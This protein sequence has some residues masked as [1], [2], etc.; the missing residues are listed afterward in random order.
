MADV[1]D[2][3]DAYYARAPLAAAARRL[4]HRRHR[5]PRARRARCRSCSTGSAP[6]WPSCAAASTGCGPTSRS[7]PATTGS[8]RTSAT[9]SAPT[10]STLDAARAAARRGQD[11]P[12]P[13]P[14]GHA[15]GPGGAGARRHRLERR[16][17]SR[18]SGGWPA[19]GTGSTR[20]SARPPSRGAAGPT[21]A[22]AAAARGPDRPADRHAGRRACRPAVRPR[23]RSC[24]HAFRRDLPHRR[25]AGRAGARRPLRHP[26]AAGVP[27]AAASFPVVGGTPVAVAG[28][29]GQY[30]FDP[31]GRQVPLSCP[32]APP[33]R[34]LRRHLDAGPRMAGARAADE[35][36]RR[37]SPSPARTPPPAPPY[38][39]RTDRGR[40]ATPSPTA[41]KAQLVAGL[42]R[43]R[44]LPGDRPAGTVVTT[45]DR[46]L[47][48]RVLRDLSAPA[49]TTATLLGDPPRPW[50]PRAPCV[51]GGSRPRRAP[52]ARSAPT[53]TVT[54]GD[55][56]T[57]DQLAD[58]GRTRGADRLAAGAR[59]AEQRPVLRPPASPP[60]APRPRGSSPAAARR[61]SSSTG[62]PSPAATSCSAARS[63][64]C[65]SP[66]APST[67]ARCTA[68]ARR[69]ARDSLSHRR[70]RRALAPVPRS[71]D[72]GRPGSPG[73][74]GT[75]SGASAN[76]SST[77]ASSARSAPGFGGSVET[78]TIT[79]SIVQ[80]HPRHDRARLHRGRRLRPALL[81]AACSPASPL[82]DA[83]ARRAACRGRAPCRLPAA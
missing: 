16:T 83:P 46:R 5:Q 1:D 10:W 33:T 57:Y 23:R 72:R 36:L 26:Q 63:T 35:A 69:T 31:T 32:P 51:T 49:R 64:R 62:S 50:S 30:V 54:I 38:P 48:V 11:H 18:A 59:R 75:G 52:W 2:G 71:V 21:F 4:P 79:D 73:A 68:A 40:P 6:R 45:A 13:A 25:H 14:Q 53:G 3:Y 8:S 44:P 61:S 81:A 12:L 43:A 82:S 7:R 67:R 70:R 34:R 60:A 41:S 22:A 42:A 39:S 47:P 9:C 29:P 28:C 19:P 66:P 20:R 58:V 74:P 78:L 27:V 65:G 15:G 17:S 55:S 37:R 56:L 76:C 24:G 77:T 80:G